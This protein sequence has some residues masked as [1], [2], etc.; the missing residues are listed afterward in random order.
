[1]THTT[2]TIGYRPDIDGLR[3][4][5]I[6]SVVLYHFG[7]PHVE[8][9]FVGVDVFFVISGYLITRLVLTDLR[10]GSFSFARFYERRVRRL[11][12][13]LATVLLATYAASLV[14]MTP[15]DFAELCKSAFYAL[16]FAANLFFADQGGYF[17][18]SL[19][20]A[21]LLHTWSL[22]V[23]EQ[24]YIV[25]PLLVVLL[26]RYAPRR[27]LAVAVL[28][29]LA[30]FAANL[31]VLQQ[32]PI[33]A[34]YMPHT[35]VW[36]LLVGCCL[37]LGIAAAPR[38][39]VA[40]V[41]GVAGLALILSAVVC[42][43]SRTQ[44]PGVAAIVPVLGA[45]LVIWSGQSGPSLAGRILTLPLPVFV[46]LVS[47]AWYLWHWPMIALFRYQ[48]ERNPS[49]IETVALVIV[50]FGLA[51][52][53]W[54]FLEKPVRH[55]AWWT[56][57]PR[58]VASGL[59]ASLSLMVLVAA[60]YASNGFIS[61]YP[62]AMGELTRERLESRPKDLDCPRPTAARIAAGD[63]CYVWNAGNNA[64]GI[65]LWGDSHAGSLTSI[66][67]DMAEP[68]HVS[69]AF[70]GE[71]AC[72]P[73]IGAGRKRR[74]GGPESCAELNVAVGNLLRERKFRDVV[75]VA[76]WDYY[77]VGV[78]TNKGPWSEQHFLRDAQSINASLDENKAVITRGLRRTVEAIVASGARAW[79][80]MEA[81]YIG[82][83]VPNQMA[84]HMMRGE[85]VDTLL[86]SSVAERK[87]RGAFMEDLVADLP[88]T[89]IDPATALCKTGRCLAVDRGK[90]L[91]YDDNHMSIYGA[92]RLMPLLTELFS[93]KLEMIGLS[94][95]R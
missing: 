7:V 94:A 59:A 43:D 18:P 51:A 47:Y 20:L 87:A 13:T 81:P 60:G 57:R 40:D 1:M 92:A 32:K 70:A 85:T 11:L 14:I 63:V 62:Q 46:G 9:G 2:T 79:V 56:P 3:A 41:A 64:P 28:L 73:L 89:V 24:F 65:L 36:E 61:R 6:V 26:F 5:S 55:G 8:G 84:R 48:T 90:P 93:R 37:A 29:L 77:A 17:S 50:S 86:G 95:A 44:F 78:P 71:A 23:E 83:N 42:F 52:L 54:R 74:R 72:A 67:R 31:S 39:I 15:Q 25:W 12:P 82:F 21:P 53:C 76:R 27:I 88:V 30:S 80:V 35:R 10:N 68:A 66:F 38:R 19:E 75:L 33:A 4:I 91:Y 22:A 69:V 34:F 16:I 58:V 49:A 45:A